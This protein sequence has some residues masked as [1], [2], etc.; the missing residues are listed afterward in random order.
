MRVTSLHSVNAGTTID[1]TQRANDYKHIELPSISMADADEAEMPRGNVVEEDVDLSD[2]AQDFRF[3]SALSSQDAKIPKRGEKDFEPHATSLQSNTLAASRQAMHNALAFQR[4]HAPKTHTLAT[5]H[6]E[7]NMA[8]CYA[9]RGPLFARMGS[10]FSAIDDPLGNDERR[11]QRLWLLP[12]EVLYLLERGTVDV[13]WPSEVDDEEGL[14][15]SLQAGYAMF[16][17]GNGGLTFERFSVYSAL[18]RQGYTVLRAPS[19][20]GPGPPTH[21]QNGPPFLAQQGLFELGLSR[22]WRT[23]FWTVREEDID[24]R[25]TLL[26]PGLYRNYS[27]IYRRLALIPFHDTPAITPDIATPATDPAFRITYHLYK[28]GNTTFKKSLPGPPDFRV[29]VIDGRATLMPTLSQLSALLDTTPYDP[30]K[31]AQQLYPTLKQGYRNVILAVVDQGVTSYMRVSDAV[32]GREKLYD[33]VVSGRGGK[34]G[35]GGRGGGRGGRGRG[36]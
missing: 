3:L 1:R 20:D 22:W 4:S 33:R 19:W 12:E 36:K 29:A 27:E 6:L 34:G 23:L 16:I 28:P 17:G 32:F 9:P 26:Q 21:A 25:E 35:R 24:Y 30:P 31:D 11:G 13:R 15:M 10:T 5:Y 18:K 8:Y 14:P 7:S 2:E